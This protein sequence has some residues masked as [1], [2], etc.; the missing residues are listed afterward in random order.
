MTTFTKPSVSAL[1]MARPSAANGNLPILTLRPA[2][3]ASS[4]VMPDRGDLRIGEDD[5]GDRAHVH[6]RL[7]PGDDL[8]DHLGLLATPCAPASAARRRRRWRRCRRR[9]CAC[10]RVDGDEARARSSRRSPP[11]PRFS[12]FGPPADGHQHLV[13]VD[14]LHLAARGLDGHRRRVAV[15][16]AQRLGLGA[17]STSTPSFFSLRATTLDQLGIGARQE[18]GSASTTVT[19]RARAWRRA[20][21]SRCR[22]S[23]RR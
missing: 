23:R 6:L 2:F 18:L 11:S 1:A 12:E 10:W 8:G 19:L 17:G 3:S 13:G 20:C 14:G 9:W 4:A 22:C 21:R 7:V 16:S 15:C 5:G